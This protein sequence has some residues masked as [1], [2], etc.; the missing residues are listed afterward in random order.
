MTQP[1]N[2][3]NKIFS[4]Q[5][6]VW[7]FQSTKSTTS[8]MKRRGHIQCKQSNRRRSSNTDS[9]TSVQ[10]E[11]SYRN[12]RPILNSCSGKQFYV[13][14]NPTQDSHDKA[15]DQVSGLQVFR[16]RQLRR[17]VRTNWNTAVKYQLQHKTFG[18]FFTPGFIIIRVRLENLKKI[19]GFKD[20][21]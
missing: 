16:A 18:L 4:L 10:P 2:L 11:D 19:N 13:S 14:S 9:I 6:L 5:T 15:T 1:R 3:V 12:Q 7:Y 17:W 8:Y 20:L 21:A